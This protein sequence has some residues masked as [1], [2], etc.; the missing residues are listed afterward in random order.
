MKKTL[1]ILLVVLFLLSLLVGCAS[2]SS[3]IIRTDSGITNNNEYSDYNY[4]NKPHSIRLVVNITTK[5][6]EYEGEDQITQY[7]YSRLPRNK[8]KII[9]FLQEGLISFFQETYD[10]DIS[11]KLKAQEIRMFSSS[12]ASEGIMG[13]VDLENA[14]V[15]NLNDRLLSDFAFAFETTY[16]HETIHQI[17]FRGEKMLLTVE[18][19]TDALTDMALCYMGIEPE[20]TEYYSEARS[21]GYQLLAADP[22]IVH[23]YIYNNNFNILQRIDDRLD[24]FSQEFRR[25]GHLGNLLE[26]RLEILY[27]I[28]N[29]TVWGYSTDPLA[30]A[31]EAQEIV[32]S[33]C[34][35]TNPSNETIDYI[36][37]HYLVTNY[38]YIHVIEDSGGYHFEITGP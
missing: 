17:G 23:C 4:W 25:S 1:S 38:E 12:G 32:F 13:F 6:V 33:Y 5:A 18:G 30:F 20:L 7:E 37:S 27:G 22:E 31:F 21:I 10:I 2:T 3:N 35:T 28:S 24:G 9:A 36:R 8:E 26:N 29:N 34:Q 19:I 16:V 14:N 15:L 11:S